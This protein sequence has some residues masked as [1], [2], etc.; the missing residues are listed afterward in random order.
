MRFTGRS[1]IST[2]GTHFRPSSGSLW[3]RPRRYSPSGMRTMPGS[4]ENAIVAVSR[5]AINSLSK[6]SGDL[7]RGDVSIRP[8]LIHI[9]VRTTRGSVHD[10]L[11]PVDAQRRIDGGQDVFHARL[12]LVVP[13]GFEALFATSVGP[14]QNRIGFDTRAGEHRRIALV[15]VI[16]AGH[17]VQGPR[18]A[19]EL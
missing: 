19:A 9:L 2:V 11:G 12:F 13:A 15:V 5:T 10:L 4:A 16:A 3:D 14:A 1:S 18:R 6:N 17:V 8:Q 7:I